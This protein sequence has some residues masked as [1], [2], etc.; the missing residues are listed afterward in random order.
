MLQSSDRKGSQKPAKHSE[1]ATNLSI[2]GQFTRFVE[3]M[4]AEM[5]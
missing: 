1:S 3:D 5:F 4:T 2:P